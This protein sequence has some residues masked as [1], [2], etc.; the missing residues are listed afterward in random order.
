MTALPC[1]PNEKAHVGDTGTRFTL[2]V[3][4][5]DNVAIDISSATTKQIL[6]RKP[7]G[8]ILTKTAIFTTDGSD[9]SVYYITLAGDLDVTGDWNYRAKVVTTETTHESSTCDLKVYAKWT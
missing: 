6:F 9:G 1:N 4:D 2:I 8:T 7:D 3:V 5:D